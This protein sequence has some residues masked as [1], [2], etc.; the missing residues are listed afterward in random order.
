[1]RDHAKPWPGAQP[2][3]VTVP[4]ERQVG[5]GGPWRCGRRVEELLA[6]YGLVLKGFNV[7]AVVTGADGP[8]TPTAIAERT[9]V[10][11]TTVTSVLDALERRALVRRSPHPTN[12]RSVLVAVTE[13]G[14][15]VCQDILRRLHGTKNLR[16]SYIGHA[17]KAPGGE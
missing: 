1:M 14:R 4:G 12:R 11:K 8:L 16:V 9:F 3:T 5:W 6:Q 2:D 13:T 10:G 15:E 7:L 17:I